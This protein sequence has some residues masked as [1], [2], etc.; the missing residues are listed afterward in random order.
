MQTPKT[1]KMSVKGE[2]ETVATVKMNDY[3]TLT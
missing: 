3:P 2:N 1:M